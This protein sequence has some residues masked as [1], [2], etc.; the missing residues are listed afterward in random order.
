MLERLTTGRALW[1]PWV[2]FLNDW[3]RWFFEINA[4]FENIGKFSSAAIQIT[5][6]L[7][8]FRHIAAIA[9]RINA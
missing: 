9:M 8:T 6:S 4:Q 1:R 5:G 2:E 3:F 7:G